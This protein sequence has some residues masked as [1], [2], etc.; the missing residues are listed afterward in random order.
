QA[1]LF[2]PMQ[3]GINVMS[4]HRLALPLVAVFA[5]MLGLGSGAKEARPPRQRGH[6]RAEEKRPASFPH[7]IWAACDFEGRTPDYAWFGPPETKTI[8]RYPG[9]APDL[10][11]SERPY[12]DFSGLMTGINP[13]PGPCMGKVN[14]LYLRYFLKGTT[15]A[16][17]QYFS[18]SREDNNHIHV[19]GLDEGKWSE[20]TL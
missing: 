3:R 11:V 10:G 17:F 7:R 12:R 14:K 8:P 18:L 2:Y 15:E 13:V 19:T 5:L 9:N 6:A 16:T 20:V 1:A 4:P